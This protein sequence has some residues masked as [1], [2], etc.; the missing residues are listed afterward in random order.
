MQYAM[1]TRSFISRSQ[2]RLNF[3]SA[4]YLNSRRFSSDLRHKG[5]GQYRNIAKGG[6]IAICA[7]GFAANMLAGFR[8]AAGGSSKDMEFEEGIKFS[9]SAPSWEELQQIIKQKR[10][11]LQLA[12]PDWEMGPTNPHALKRTFG[13]DEQIRVKL[14]RDHAAWCP[15]CQKVWFQL[16]EKQIPYTIEK[17]NMR[18]YGDKPRE[19]MQKVPG[20]LLP[21]MEIDGKIVTESAE[22]AK[23]L[24]REFPDN[25]LLPPEGS[26]DRNY[27]NQLMKLERALFGVWCQWLCQPYNQER[28]KQEYIQ[29]LQMV[30]QS[31]AYKG[32]PYFL[33][34]E[35]SLIDIIFVPFLER[36]VASLSYYKGY[37][38]RGT[39]EW[40]NIENWFNA[41]ETRPTYLGTKSDHFT[42][43][44]D[45]PPQLGGCHMT[46]EGTPVAAAIDGQDGKSWE[47]PL[48][49][50]NANSLEPYSPE[51]NL[52]IDTLEAA[53]KLVGN[54]EAVVRFAGRGCGQQGARPVSAPL[55]DP[56]AV[57]GEEYLQSVDAA[58]RCVAAALL[59]GYQSQ[60]ID[61]GGE[62]QGGPTI[63]ALEYLRDRVGVPRDLKLPAA[64]QLRAHLNWAIHQ[65]SPA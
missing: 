45:L 15:Y 41:L 54:H 37:R 42:H 22:I 1:I 64:R 65:L 23:I 44:H 18:C 58:L 57:P 27:V 26:E 28:A 63:A 12:E 32:G 55:S 30:D 20:G 43:C 47:L 59:N 9:D 50:L 21:V 3:K 5:G 48:P 56:T 6:V 19:F 8:K 36:M 29:V 4:N 24:E 53:A 62:L 17:I 16:E 7:A 51:E 35:L 13:K 10:E 40:P 49:P 11:K 61:K 39:G 14:Y 34:S 31:L 2:Q 33:G 46:S 38:I 60:N 52:E 25:P